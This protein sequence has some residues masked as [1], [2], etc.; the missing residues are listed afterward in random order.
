MRGQHKVEKEQDRLREIEKRGSQGN[1][2][3]NDA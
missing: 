1:E 2:A 3:S